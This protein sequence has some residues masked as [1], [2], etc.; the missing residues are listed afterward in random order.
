MVTPWWQSV[1]FWRFVESI[2]LDI[3]SIPLTASGPRSSVG[4]KRSSLERAKVGHQRTGPRRLQPVAAYSQQPQIV[5]ADPGRQTSR[6]LLSTVTLSIRRHRSSNP[7]SSN[8]KQ[9]LA[10]GTDPSQKA[11]VFTA[12]MFK[13]GIAAE[14]IPNALAHAIPRQI[15]MRDGQTGNG[16]LHE[17]PNYKIREGSVDHTEIGGR[18]AIRA[19]GEFERNGKSFAELLAWAYSEHTRTYF[20]VRGATENLSLLQASF[21]QMLQSAKIP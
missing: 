7:I 20:M 18:Q 13:G 8:Q 2:T 12:N 3:L 1:D 11:I 9:P 6:R 14:N 10:P 5:S 21:D 16:P 19:I 15:A 4:M 17:A